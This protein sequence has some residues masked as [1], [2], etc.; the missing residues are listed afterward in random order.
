[1]SNFLRVGDRVNGER[2]RDPSFTRVITRLQPLM[3]RYVNSAVEQELST[4]AYKYIYTE[5]HRIYHNA[6]TR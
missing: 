2:V 5:C 4:E 1:M 6:K 3:G